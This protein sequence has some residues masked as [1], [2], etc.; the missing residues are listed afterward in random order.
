MPYRK[1]PFLII[2][3]APSGGG[4][5]TI[6]NEILN[7]N[8]QIEYSVSYT[9]RPPRGYE[10][11][12]IHYNFVSR[13]AFEQMIK[14]GDFL[15]HAQ[16]AGHYYGTSISYIQSRLA[17]GKHV[18]MDIDVQGAAQISSKDIPYVKIFLMPPSL[19]ILKE[20]LI[21][22][23]TDSSEEIEKRLQ[24]ARTEI[25]SI[26]LYDYLVINDRLDIAVDDVRA[27]IRAE[28]NRVDR[29]SLPET[30][31]LKEQ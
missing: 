24:I 9:T 15:E 12:G 29:Y 26:P 28:E 7:D 10:Q 3:S 27:I 11:N 21:N 5:S 4:K 22:R 19:K 31:F 20:R 18:I 23:K 17:Q 1:T 6:L 16:F 25:Q 2:L 8:N 13:E 14:A 30:E